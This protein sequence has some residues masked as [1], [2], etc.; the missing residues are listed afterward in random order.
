MAQGVDAGRPEERPALAFSGAL[1]GAGRDLEG[2]GQI[3]K[4][5]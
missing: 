2:A 1:F 5:R 4:P 3:E